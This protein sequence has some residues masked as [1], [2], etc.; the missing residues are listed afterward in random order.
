MDFTPTRARYHPLYG[1]ELTDA[2]GVVYFADT[3]LEFMIQGVVTLAP[4]EGY[5]CPYREFVAGTEENGYED[6]T[7]NATRNPL[8]VELMRRA[9]DGR[10][11]GP[12]GVEWVEMPVPTYLEL[13]GRWV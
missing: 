7:L 3:K 10:H 6:M 12:K 8:A 11:P 9:D 4:R 2:A 5:Y 1:L 13:T